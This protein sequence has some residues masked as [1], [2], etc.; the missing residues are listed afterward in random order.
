MKK[1]EFLFMFL[2]WSISVHAQG[3]IQDGLVKIYQGNVIG[4]LVSCKKLNLDG[5]AFQYYENGNIERQS[6]YEKDK[7]H[8][9]TK[10]FSKEN[11]LTQVKV[12]DQ[13][14]L[15]SVQTFNDMGELVE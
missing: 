15:V 13:D 14:K 2:T 10:Y 1:I 8:G 4:N 12:Y 7:L 9:L 3:K 11:G 5:V 6:W